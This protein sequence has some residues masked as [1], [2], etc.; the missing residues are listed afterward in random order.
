MESFE[1]ALL[2]GVQD[3]TPTPLS[4]RLLLPTATF[5]V[6]RLLPVRVFAVILRIVVEAYAIL[7]RQ[8]ICV[9]VTI[10]DA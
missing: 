10:V 4:Y 8:R 9:S 2:A 5:A 7:P 1:E 6:F 3:K